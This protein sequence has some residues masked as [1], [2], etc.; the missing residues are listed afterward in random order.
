MG[1]SA[2]IAVQQPDGTFS[3]ISLNWDGYPDHAGRVLREHYGTK[4]QRDGLLA[5]G[6]LSVIGKD[7]G[8]GPQPWDDP[9]RDTCLAYGRDRGEG[10]E[11]ACYAGDEEDVRNL[12]RGHNYLYL[13]RDGA[14]HWCKGCRSALQPL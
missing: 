1:T 6:N 3:T 11:Q 13:W 5:L 7:L 14:W 12:A 10:G 4:E 9:P 8:T 2:L